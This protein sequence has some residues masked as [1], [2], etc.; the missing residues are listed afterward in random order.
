M[1]S[2]AELGNEDG[3][4]SRSP[5]PNVPPQEPVSLSFSPRIVG[6]ITGGTFPHELSDHSAMADEDSFPD[7]RGEPPL[8]E[9]AWVTITLWLAPTPAFAMVAMAIAVF[10][11][12]MCFFFASA[13]QSVVGWALCGFFAAPA[14]LM[15]AASISRHLQRRRLS[16]RDSRRHIDSERLPTAAIIVSLVSVFSLMLM[17]G[18]HVFRNF[19]AANRPGG[20]KY[21]VTLGIAL[22]S[23]MY[24]TLHGRSVFYKHFV[25]RR[26]R[27]INVT[28]GQALVVIALLLVSGAYFAWIM[29]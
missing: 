15:G 13:E 5:F 9:P 6:N 26:G 12:L 18:L 20:L 8:P 28:A 29:G 14:A 23:S 27:D 22:A 7:H 1:R 16:A 17:I 25:A 10:A 4:A 21:N 3:S 11:S 24:M 2:Q 19:F